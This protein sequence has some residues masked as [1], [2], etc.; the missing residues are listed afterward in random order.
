MRQPRQDSLAFLYQLQFFGVKLGLDNIRTLLDSVGR[1]QDDLRIVHIAGTNGKGSTAAALANIFHAA[2]LS[3]GLYTSPHLQ[4]FTERIRID[5]RPI[6]VAELGGLIEELRP[7][8]ERLR[9]TFFELSTALALLSFQRQG[10]KWAILETGM[11]G[12]LDATNLVEP[13]LCLLTPIAFD[14]A[15]H[16]GNDL[17]AIAAE[18]AGILKPGVPLISAPQP[19]SAEQVIA[20]RAAAVAAPLLQLERDFCWSNSAAGGI[21]TGGG[22]RIA[23]IQPGLKGEHQQ[24]NLALAGAAAAWLGSNGE[25][26]SAAAIKQGLEQV[27]WPGRLEWL[28]ERI[29][30]DGAHNQA[31]A[32]TLAA[33]LQ[34]EK[35]TPVHLVV[36]CKADKD[37]AALLTPLLP[38]CGRIY[39]VPAPVEA[40]VAVEDLVRLALQA[41]LPARAY[42]RPA[43][44]LAA[45]RQERGPEE[46][47][48]VAGSL[49]LV[50]AVREQLVESGSLA[51]CA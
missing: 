16:L 43:Q 9:A 27:R 21:L 19:R 31:G 30:L 51:I 17:A 5:L 2:G 14:H 24:Q 42:G 37:Y 12:R 22:Y 45:A 38:C 32:E 47:L 25:A 13:E 40:A 10:V 36:G 20:R 28:P 3:A 44:A 8:A 49:F 6:D 29:L 7:L 1:P 41:G 33:Y 34:A 15:V 35:L 46:V 23:G 48:V 50:A 26:L 11:G 39:A 4:G 18:K